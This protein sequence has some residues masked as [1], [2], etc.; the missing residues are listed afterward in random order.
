MDIQLKSA[1]TK[2]TDAGEYSREGRRSKISRC[3]LAVGEE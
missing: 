3:I 2:C 1:K